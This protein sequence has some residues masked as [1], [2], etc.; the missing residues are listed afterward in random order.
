M[1]DE[2]TPESAF[3]HG[4]AEVGAATLTA[5]R[6]LEVAFRRMGP[7][8]FEALRAGM[9]P[10]RERLEAALAEWHE[11]PLPDGLEDLGRRLREGAEA[12][13]AG[14]ERAAAP[15]PEEILR[16]MRDHA[17]AQRAMYPLRTVFPPLGRFFAEEHRWADLAALDPEPREGIR[18]GLHHAGGRDRDQRGGFVFYVPEHWDGVARWPLVVA[19]HGG[20]GHG[21]DFLWT[22]L[23]E[24]RSRGFFLLAPTSRGAT[25]SLMGPDLDAVPL[26]QMIDFVAARWPVDRERV[27]LTGLSDG[28]TF[29]LLAGLA[30]GAPYT[31]LAP[32]SGVFHP[33]NAVNG[34]LERAAG[35]RIRLVH[36]A[37]DW[38]FP[39]DS[40][41]EARDT[42]VA[43]GADLVFREIDDLSHAY[44]R[45]ENA[46]ILRWFDPALVPA[47]SPD[48][49]AG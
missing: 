4:V 3:T 15:K 21:M 10:V 47:G 6:A 12:A 32:V 48:A 1:S 19:L 22:W 20:A 16:A 49:E 28:A 8:G 36:G 33:L 7:M 40:A 9:A 39:I 13:R 5:L 30:E 34:N 27:L 46:A 2:Q 37:L 25:W 42:L 11:Q 41:R 31:A 29:T 45:E 38:M 26:S 24:A 43:A 23:R 35:R 17:R 18:I 14:L 44:P